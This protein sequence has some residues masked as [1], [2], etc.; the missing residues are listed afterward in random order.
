MSRSKEL[1]RPVGSGLI[2]DSAKPIKRGVWDLYE[3]T[4]PRIGIFEA[5]FWLELDDDVHNID[6]DKALEE[7]ATFIR[8]NIKSNIVVIEHSHHIMMG[9]YGSGEA[10]GRNFLK[11]QPSRKRDAV[12]DT[13][14]EG[15]EIRLMHEDAVTFL[16][17]WQ[18]FGK[19]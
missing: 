18:G 15:F 19:Q 6:R 3:N 9:G 7:L 1:L 16:A 13:I 4:N 10:A 11:P 2:H 8:D 5:S 14:V 17:L 12:R